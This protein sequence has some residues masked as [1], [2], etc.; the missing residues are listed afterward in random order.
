MPRVGRFQ[1]SA[2]STRTKITL[3]LLAEDAFNI[4]AVIDD[5]AQLVPPAVVVGLLFAAK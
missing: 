4:G 3:K 2:P 1:S 5:Q